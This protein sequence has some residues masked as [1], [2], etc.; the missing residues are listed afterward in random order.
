MKSGQ[1]INMILAG[2]AAAAPAA[3]TLRSSN[4]RFDNGIVATGII[5]GILFTASWLLYVGVWGRD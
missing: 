3:P 1:R 2:M 4:H 5:M